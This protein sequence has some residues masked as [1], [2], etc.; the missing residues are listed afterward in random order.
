MPLVS[1]RGCAFSSASSLDELIRFREVSISFLWD[2]ML[3]TP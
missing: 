1:N 2:F 3:Y